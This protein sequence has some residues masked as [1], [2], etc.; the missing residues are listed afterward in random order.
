MSVAGADNPFAGSCAICFIRAIMFPGLD[1][2]A[3]GMRA[4]IMSEVVT[5]FVL[6]ASGAAAGT[7]R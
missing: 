2:P 6:W 1:N 4:K 3:I 5:G 7:R